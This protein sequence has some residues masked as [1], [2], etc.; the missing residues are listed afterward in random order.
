MSRAAAA[1]G[2]RWWVVGTD[3]D[4]DNGIMAEMI[5]VHFEQIRS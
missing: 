1:A 2:G 4:N 3:S 5:A